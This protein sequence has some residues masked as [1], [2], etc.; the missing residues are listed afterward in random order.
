MKN[1]ADDH[2]RMRPHDVDHGVAAELPKVV[3][4]DHRIFVTTPDVVD[5]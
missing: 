4:A 3:R 1:A 5:P 2:H